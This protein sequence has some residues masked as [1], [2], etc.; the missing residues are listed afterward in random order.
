[1]QWSTCSETS[2]ESAP[3]GYPGERQTS[4]DYGYGGSE[5]SSESSLQIVPCRQLKGLDLV[6]DDF[7]SSFASSSRRRKRRDFAPFARWRPVK[8]RA[9][10]IHV[11]NFKE[12]EQQNRRRSLSEYFD[13]NESDRHRDRENSMIRETLN[14]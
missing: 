7:K 6:S 13:K 2:T 9:T 1:M 3:A 10:I 11:P 14:G 4:F 5:Q 12:F 8:R